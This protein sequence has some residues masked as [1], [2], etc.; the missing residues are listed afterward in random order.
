ML[1]SRNHQVIQQFCNYIV[2]TSVPPSPHITLCCSRADTHSCKTIP[3]EQ[4]LHVSGDDTFNLWL[5]A[6]VCY[7]HRNVPWGLDGWLGSQGVG[8]LTRRHTARKI[9]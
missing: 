6:D 3:Y 4:Q 5:E 1:T 2:D 8:L 9:R 7:F